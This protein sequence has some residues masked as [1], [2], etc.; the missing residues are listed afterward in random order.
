MERLSTVPP[1]T[2]GF[3]QARHRAG[4]VKLD[5]IITHARAGPRGSTA[6]A[7]IW[8]MPTT[9]TR[10]ARASRGARPWV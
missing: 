1:R 6:S 5:P 3:S 10:R 2:D 7:T 8:R 4:A 9:P